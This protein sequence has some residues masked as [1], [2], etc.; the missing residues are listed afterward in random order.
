MLH[1][2]T[3]PLLLLLV[4]CSLLAGRALALTN[5][6]NQPIQLSADSVDIDQATGQS[7]YKGHVD[8]RQG[9]MRL[10][11]DR[12]TILSRGKKPNK[13]IAKGDVHFTQQ[14]DTGVVKATAQVADYVVNSEL[15][16]L[17][18]DAALTQ[19]GDT[20]RSDRI[21][22]DRVQHK[23]KAGGAAQG[24]QRVNITIQPQQH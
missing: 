7:I 1:R 18:G 16:E 8:M 2:P 9:S 14:T 19:N 10:R 23:V 11:A 20:M 17:T 13:V 3:K 15:L 12:V 24:R 22:Y 21:I 5:D 4:C 6:K